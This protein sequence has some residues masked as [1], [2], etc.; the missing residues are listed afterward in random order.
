MRLF[1]IFIIAPVFILC[2]T[3]S[4]KNRTIFSDFYLF[5]LRLVDSA[6]K[7]VYTIYTIKE[8]IMKEKR[9][10]TLDIFPQQ[11][12]RCTFTIN[13]QCVTHIN[14]ETELVVVTNGELTMEIENEK[15]V[16]RAGEG[17]F[18]QPF[19]SH[20]FESVDCGCYIML[21]NQ[22]TGKRFYEFLQN[23]KPLTRVFPIP[24][25]V[26]NLVEYICKKEVVRFDKMKA[27][28]VLA[29]L[30]SVI[31][32][33]CRFTQEKNIQKTII[34]AALAIINQNLLLD[35]TLSAVAEEIGCHPVTLSKAFNAYTGISFSAYIVLRR[36]YLAKLL[37]EESEQTI[38]E[39]ALNSGFGSLRDFNR[40][41]KK[42]FS[43][44]PSQ[45]R[46]SNA[47]F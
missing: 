36:C 18:V 22:S 9:L 10:K 45:Y 38:T 46:K 11:D 28:S 14:L 26:L 8:I 17:I 31:A 21:F 19:E 43:L 4:F 27:E 16:I 2:K 5:A 41:F 39:I 34:S 29:P 44:T 15:Y 30:L 32:E 47:I 7:K 40:C 1:S 25:P 13:V 23:K 33:N 3:I 35:V 20:S 24:A 12:F 37:L 42:V 6:G